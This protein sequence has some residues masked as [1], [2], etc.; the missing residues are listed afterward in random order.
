MVNHVGANHSFQIPKVKSA[1]KQGL[2][3]PFVRPPA[4]KA[5]SRETQVAFTSIRGMR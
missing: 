1:L 4:G 3:A 2:Q 5:L